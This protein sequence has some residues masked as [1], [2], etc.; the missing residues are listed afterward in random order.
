MS[1]ECPDPVAFPLPRYPLESL[2]TLNRLTGYRR[3]LPFEWD[4][5]PLN[6]EFHEEP[7][8]PEGEWMI[9]LTFEGHP[10]RAIL[11]KI[12]EVSW[13][14]PDLAGVRLE[15]LPEELAA[16]VLEVC[17]EAMTGNVRGQLD[18]RI[19]SISRTDG[20]GAVEDGHLSVGCS[21]ARGD[22]PRWMV[23]TLSGSP[24]AMRHL[25]AS[26]SRVAAEPDPAFG[27]VPVVL[28]FFIGGFTCS[29]AEL[30]S[31]AVN[32]V[33]M[34]DFG[35]YPVDG[36]CTI[37]A[38]SLPL[39]MGKVKAGG[40]AITKVYDETENVATRRAPAP[41]AAE[42]SAGEPLQV[43][44]LLAR[45]TVPARVLGQLGV[46]KLLGIPLQPD[47]EVSMLVSSK[48]IGSGQLVRV[49]SRRGLRI[50]NLTES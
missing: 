32:D 11:H 42:G 22:I 29:H 40:I 45:R 38:G 9:Q 4:G 48:M 24:D 23:G 15:P 39:G 2:A 17:L 5:R 14:F 33:I 8:P 6:F 26:V 1:T 35:T 7:E 21:V 36:S 20:R 19:Q 25:A 46:G 49:G 34:G 18:L 31:L 10:L 3:Q 43:E 12:P 16:A 13:M 41:V 50:N 37:V 47:P 44:F 30:A 28:G 27:E